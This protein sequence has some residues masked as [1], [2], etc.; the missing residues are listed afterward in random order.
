MSG[1]YQ[2][3]QHLSILRTDELPNWWMNGL[4]EGMK[5]I[6]ISSQIQVGS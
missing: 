1:K 3:F 5:W 4:K 2:A 6:R